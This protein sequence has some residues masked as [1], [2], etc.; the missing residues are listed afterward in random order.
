MN[1]PWRSTYLDH[2]FGVAGFT[3]CVAGSLP[4]P[5][6]SSSSGGGNDVVINTVCLLLYNM[7]IV[8]HNDMSS[9]I[10]YIYIYIHG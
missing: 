6:G 8:S 9:C 3:L 7:L 1:S 4:D 10:L 2:Y 5:P